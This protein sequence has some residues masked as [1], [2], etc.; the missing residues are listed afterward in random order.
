MEIKAPVRGYELIDVTDS[1][2]AFWD[3]HQG[4]SLEKQMERFVSDVIPAHPEVYAP[5]VIDLDQDMSADEAL[6]IRLRRY[7]P[8]ASEKLDAIRAAHIAVADSLHR[9]EASF[10]EAFDDFAFTGRI[11]VTASLGAFDGATR[12]VDGEKALLFAV[13]GIGFLHPPGSN[14]APFFH[15]EIFHLYHQQAME[16]VGA[17]AEKFSIAR[18]L[19]AEGL[20][21]H[22]S[23]VLNP[24]AT[25]QDLL[26]NDQMVVDTDARM[27]ELTADLAANL[28]SS[29]KELY[30][31]YFLLRGGKRV[32]RRSSY[33]IGMR[34]AERA[35]EGRTLKQLARLHGVERTRAIEEA[36]RALGADAPQP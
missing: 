20:A 24:G 30:A 21:V 3:Q 15:H 31:E 26:L 4:A 9:Y 1:Y 7:L 36:L 25:Y 19:W 34:V 8:K 27:A 32:P 13:D 2:F 17:D 14:P 29:D 28:T 11:D 22:V 33:Y 10:L 6:L 12:T 23:R 35:A 5:S 18:E 16:E